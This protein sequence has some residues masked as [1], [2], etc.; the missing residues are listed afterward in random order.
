MNVIAAV[1]AYVTKMTDENE[2][3]MK[4]L[5]MDKD[6]T[7]TISMVCG[8]SEIQQKEVYL[9]ERID[10][11]NANSNVGLNYLK[12]IV[13]LRPTPQNVDLLSKELRNPRYGSYYIYFTNIVAKADIKILA[14]SDEQEVVK[15]VQ[16]LYMDYLAVNPHLFSVGLFKCIDGLSFPSHFLI[17]TVQSLSA[18]L[19]SLKKTPLIR[20]QRKSKFCKELAQKLDELINKE[21]SLFA[22]GQNSYPV[23]LI[24]DRRDDPVTPLLN[25]WTYQAMV[26]ELLTINNNRVN[27]SNI[28]GVSK[29]L[30]EVV[31]SADQDSFYAKNI[32]LNFGEIG[33]N[34]KELMEHFQAKAKS[35]QKVESIAD[36]KAFV[37]NYPQFK[38]L[39]GN[40]AKHVTVIG[41]LSSIVAKHDLLQVSEIEQ[42]I[43][44]QNDHSSQLQSIRKLVNEKNV[45]DSDATKLVMLYALKYRNHAGN[46][47]PALIKLLK[48]RGISNF[49]LN[50]ILNVLE[51]A[52]SHACENDLFNV[53]SAVKITKRFFK[54]LSGVDNVYTQHKPLLHETVEELIKGRLNEDL[55]PNT[56]IGNQHFNGRVQ[57]IFVFMIGGTT[58]EESYSVFTLNATYQGI[59]I[60]LGGTT[61]H[62][63]KTFLEEVENAVKNIPKKHTKHLS[64][65]VV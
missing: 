10:N 25:Q 41:E 62:N 49:L 24:L 13:L 40:V 31:L 36:M 50:S 12:C 48:K 4:I 26:H 43:A 35:H 33:Q 5:L 64:H 21:S 38:K 2:P 18:V 44:S 52:G 59:N 46:E 22:F 61:I 32:F 23:L 34:I 8:K 6:T 58:Y 29:E 51:Y 9:L 7:S 28:P 57:D 54:G 16:E 14:E 19:L 3:G 60:I 15:E 27:L 45:R 37:E 53:E 20:Y 17:R 1:K 63:S 65:L 11:I 39:S 55:Y 47:V 42:E 56:S 30:S